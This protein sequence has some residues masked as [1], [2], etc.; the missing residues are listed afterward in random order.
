MRARVGLYFS[1]TFVL[2]QNVAF[3]ETATLRGQLSGWLIANDQDPLVSQ[4]GIQYIPELSVE[5][6]IGS[7]YVIDAVASPRIYGTIN[8]YDE[9]NTDTETKIKEYRL[10]GR[11]ASN[12][13]E[14]RIGLQKINFGSATLF[15]PLRWFDHID[16]RDPLQLT[17]GV[18]ALLMRYYFQNN[19]NIW[20]W[21]LYGNDDPKGREIAPTTNNTVEF[22]GRV[23]VPLFTGEAGL[24]YHHREADFSQFS[25][26]VAEPSADTSVPE[27]RVGLDGKWDLGVGVW[28]EGAISRH[29]TDITALKYQQELTVGMDYT[30]GIGNGLYVLGEHFISEIS[31]T[32]FSSGEG[33]SFSG[34]SLDYPLGLMDNVSAIVSYD[35]DNNDWY[36]TFTWKRLYDNWS[37]FLIGFW[38]PKQAL[39]NQNRDTDSDFSGKGVQLMVVFNH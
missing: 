16:P 7:Q 5:Q 15:R 12:R 19:A 13:F 9:E 38:N 26:P 21:G 24:S 14:S 4:I 3:S 11:F 28:F 36:R 35:W 23:Q 29:K 22:G 37:F 10:W 6:T 17:D 30:F 2:W 25:I 31:D 20:L 32:A 33:S 39:L 27:N 8:F 1:L 34:L 18:Y